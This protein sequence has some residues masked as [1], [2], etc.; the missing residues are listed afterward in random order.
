MLSTGIPLHWSS[1]NWKPHQD[2]SEKKICS[3][4]TCNTSWI[5]GIGWWNVSNFCCPKINSDKLLCLC[6]QLNSIYYNSL[7]S[8]YSEL[9]DVFPW[10]WIQLPPASIQWLSAIIICLLLW[11]AEH[12]FGSRISFPV[13]FLLNN[14]WAFGLHNKHVIRITL[15]YSR[16]IYSQQRKHQKVVQN[17]VFIGH[18][19]STHLAQPLMKSLQNIILL[20][21]MSCRHSL[22]RCLQQYKLPVILLLCVY[23]SIVHSVLCCVVYIDIGMCS[24]TL[25]CCTQ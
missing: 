21:I 25:C 6:H 7:C 11:K 12:H 2:L 24:T 13:H 5:Y 9:A 10:G 14:L 23:R 3:D 17:N 19:V 20:W 4:N 16:R 18:T 15:E 8:W 1:T 22:L